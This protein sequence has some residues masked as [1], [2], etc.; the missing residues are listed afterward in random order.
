MDGDA[1]L[2]RQQIHRRRIRC[3]H[4]SLWGWGG[5]RGRWQRKWGSGRRARVSGGWAPAVCLRVVVFLATNHLPQYFPPPVEDP[6]GVGVVSIGLT[7]L[8]SQGG[9]IGSHPPA[10]PPLSWS[11]EKTTE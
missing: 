7:A 3:F 11:P 4:A 8:V 9:D 6:P 10:Q 1:R 5:R 2:C